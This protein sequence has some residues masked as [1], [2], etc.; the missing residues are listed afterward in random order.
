MP[1][2]YSKKRNPPPDPEFDEI[3]YIPPRPEEQLLIQ[4][5]ASLQAERILCTSHGRGQ[6]AGYLASQNPNSQVQCH[7]LDSHYAAL[8]KTYWEE[9][10][11]RPE[12]ICSPDLP[13]QEYDVVCVPVQRQGNA[14]LT[15][16]M[17][18]Q[19]YLRLA[20][21]GMMY[22]AVNTPQDRWLHEQMQTLHK[23]VT[24]KV[25]KTG[26][27]YSATKTGPLNKVRNFTSHFTAKVKERELAFETRPG[28]FSHR[29]L[30]P[31]AWA[32]IR[33]MQ[34][35]KGMQVL[36]LGC[37][38]GAVGIAAMCSAPNVSVTAIDSYSRAVQCTQ[39]NIEKNL[40]AAEQS[41]F[42]IVQT[43]SGEFQHDGQF[44][45][46]L[47]NPP[48]FANFKIAQLFIETALNAMKPNGKFFLVTKMPHW[49]EEHLPEYFAEIRIDPQGDYSI[50]KANN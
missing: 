25:K 1:R 14:E 36:D 23:K 4:H 33:S 49:Y 8:S 44:D 39:R 18:Q 16:E 38:C 17:L 10:D 35:K 48:Y 26:V 40:D 46:V 9:A 22:C 15:R 5:L 34:V 12:I 31:G 30:D 37:G 43:H 13:D 24:R 27:I 20:D 32:L 41:R 21:K 6:L 50:V 28:V 7:Y 2:K 42:T 45:L 29:R 47:A 19:A 11:H 3:P